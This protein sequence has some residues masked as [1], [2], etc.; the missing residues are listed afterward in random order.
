[1][2]T[3]PAGL[4]ALSKN[5]EQLLEDKNLSKGDLCE[6]AA[7]APSTLYRNLKA[8]EAF[9]FKQIGNIAA[10]LEVPIIELVKD[11]A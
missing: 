2:G 6:R 8:P 5:I 11:A 9:S 4:T 3:T 7:I 10:A 1:M